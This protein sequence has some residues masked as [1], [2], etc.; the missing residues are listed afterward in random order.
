MGKLRLTE[1]RYN[2]MMEFWGNDEDQVKAVVN[3]WGAKICNKGYTI[4][5]YDFT[6][7]FELCKIDDVGA[8]ES[9]YDAAIQAEKDGIKIIPSYQLPENMPYNMKLHQWIDT[10][11]NREAIINYCNQISK[12]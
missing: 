1:K 12:W 6:G 8:F 3:D 7:L 2:Q 10:R 4:F 11:A 9:D 5:D